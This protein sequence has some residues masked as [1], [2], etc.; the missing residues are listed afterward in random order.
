MSSVVPGFEP[1]RE[2]L[3]PDAVPR[4]FCFLSPAKHRKL[5]KAREAR[6]LHRSIIKDLLEEPRE[7]H[8]SMYPEPA[9]R[10][11]RIQCG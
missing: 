9:T 10:Y 1:K 2:M 11:I 7:P 3:K 4:V 6:T 8:F 5:S